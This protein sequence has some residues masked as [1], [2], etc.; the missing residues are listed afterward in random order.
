MDELSLPAVMTIEGND[1]RIAET[2]IRNTALKNQKILT[3]DSL[4]SVTSK[5]VQDGTT[6]L[7]VMENNLRILKEALN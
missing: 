2:I 7:S 1:H 6:Y 5:D 3:M 4:Q